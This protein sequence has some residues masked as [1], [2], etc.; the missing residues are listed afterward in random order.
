MK[1]VTETPKQNTDKK[2]ESKT[3]EGSAAEKRSMSENVLS[4]KKL[5]KLQKNPE[6]QFGIKKFIFEKCQNC[7][8]P[9]DINFYII[10]KTDKTECACE[11]DLSEADKS[12]L[13]PVVKENID[14]STQN[15]VL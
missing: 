15:A 2:T 5:K 10:P 14:Y 6:K 8:N 4:R 9:K 11:S 13:N 3:A 12:I 7:L 1:P